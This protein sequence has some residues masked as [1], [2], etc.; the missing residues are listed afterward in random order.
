MHNMGHEVWL[1]RHGQSMANAGEM[2]TAPGSAGLTDLGKRQAAMIAAAIPRKPER[3]IVSPYDR[4]RQTAGPSIARFPDSAVEEWPLQEF[5]YLLP[6]KYN[7]TT[8][9]QRRPMENEYWSRLDPAYVEGQGTESFL[10]MFDRVEAAWERLRRM[11]GFTLIFSHGQI[12]RAFFM[13]LFEGFLDYRQD[14]VKAMT[15][16]LGLRR[17]LFI[18]NGS[19]MRIGLSEANADPLFGPLSMAHIPPELHSR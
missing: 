9:E 3:I 18:P 17:G 6:A 10:G 4:T 7:G 13:L 14:P 19:I 12:M 5:T 8:L 16:F 11:Q 15:M 2:T 1:I